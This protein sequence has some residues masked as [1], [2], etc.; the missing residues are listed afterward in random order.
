MAEFTPVNV[1]GNFLSG[2]QAKQDYESN[3]LQ[4]KQQQ[5][6]HLMRQKQF[7]QQQMQ[8]S[9]EQ[10]KQAA[11]KLYQAAQ[12][13]LQSDRPKAFLEANYPELVQLAGPAWA[14]AD[15]NMVRQKMQDALGIYGPKAGIGPGPRTVQYQTIQGPRG[16]VIQVNPET[17][18]QRQ[19]IG[20]DNSQASGGGPPAGYRWKGDKLE[21]I[22]GGPADPNTPSTKDDQRVFAKADKL[23]D[24]FNAQSKDFII[25]NDAFNTVKQVA[26]D[27]SA[28]GDLSMIFAYMKMLDP[29]S[30]VR[31]QEFANA[32]NAAGVPQ[33]VQNAYNKLL[34]G[35][36][37]SEDQRKDF[38]NQANNL[39]KVKN[40][41]QQ[42]IVKRYT[43]IA[44]RNRVN[45]EDVV[46]DLSVVLGEEK[47]QP[48]G[49]QQNG[50]RLTPE[51]ASK[52][53]PG[54]PFIGMDGIERV[55]R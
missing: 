38:I 41:R 15:D 29:N 11:T 44:K 10:K 6:N 5:E 13:A 24:E 23:R 45:P 2:R 48:G 26:T 50:Q 20:P 47:E 18:E 16:S 39:Y 52:L 32:Q 37:L 31:E 22:P 12:Y 35:E 3:Q 27:H 9:E 34:S 4:M 21:P 8:L 54:T 43:D 30:V 46:G 51:Q 7:E 25:V 49:Q 28:A 55:K 42:T 36:R 19:V 40:G 17:N 33:R 1:V 53:P 14:T